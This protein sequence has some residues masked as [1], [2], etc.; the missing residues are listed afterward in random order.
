MC[1]IWTILPI[2][3]DVQVSH[4]SVVTWRHFSEL[5][6]FSQTAAAQVHPQCHSNICDCCS[7][8]W[9]QRQWF[10]ALS[11]AYAYSCGWHCESNI[12]GPQ[13]WSS[14]PRYGYIYIRMHD[15]LATW[16]HGYTEIRKHR[17]TDTR[18]T[19]IHGCTDRLIQPSPLWLDIYIYNLQ[20]VFGRMHGY[21]DDVRCMMWHV[22][23]LV[24]IAFFNCRQSVQKHT[25]QESTEDVKKVKK[26]SYWDF[27]IQW[28]VS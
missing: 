6:T 13:C 16:L 20:H 11:Q 8:R 18:I 4:S 22:L 5:Q 3:P 27:W 7:L 24:Q 26:K 23:S 1:Q 12:F 19:R 15:R 10:S 2:A 17:C 9:I 28:F 25:A 21:M 14:L